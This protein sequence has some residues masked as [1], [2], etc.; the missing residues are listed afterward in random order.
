[1]DGKRFWV[2]LFLFVLGIWDF[3]G[4]RGVIDWFMNFGF[5]FWGFFVLL[6]NCFCDLFFVVSF[7]FVLYFILLFMFFS[8]F[9][10]R[11]GDFG[12][13]I[14]FFIFV[15]KFKFFLLIGVLNLSGLESILWISF[16]LCRDDWKR[17]GE[18]VVIF[19]GYFGV[20]GVEVWMWI[21]VVVV[22]FCYWRKWLLIWEIILRLF[23]DFIIF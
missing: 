8:C 14:I 23:V 21:V 18:V 20:D 4:E 19:E 12:F 16:V 2:L 6:L 22:D 15:L 3:V 11:L 17:K 9:L 7:F 10:I 5:I 1:M 13:E